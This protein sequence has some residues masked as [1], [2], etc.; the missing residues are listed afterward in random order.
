MARKK[1][2]VEVPVFA[3]VY[4][5]EQTKAKCEKKMEN[6]PLAS[7]IAIAA[8]V[9][10]VLGYLVSK[11]YSPI[12]LLGNVLYLVAIIGS[13]VTYVKIGGL[14][15]GVKGAF[16]IAKAGWFLI[17][18]FPV[19]LFIFLVAL[20]F[21]IY[22]LFLIPAVILFFVKKEILADLYAAEEYLER[23]TAQHE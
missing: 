21:S 4:E 7:K 8:S 22:A 23:C 14:G 3:S 12:A 19:D 2:V 20:I 10:T 9:C 1:A 6:Y 5:A 18:I 17:P 13:I 15:I 11:I 16:K